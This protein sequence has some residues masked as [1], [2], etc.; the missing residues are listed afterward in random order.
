MQLNALTGAGSV[1]LKI[2]TLISSLNNQLDR[3][4]K[5]TFN[6]KANYSDNTSQNEPLIQI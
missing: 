2:L 6:V 3:A 5:S 4:V 1:F